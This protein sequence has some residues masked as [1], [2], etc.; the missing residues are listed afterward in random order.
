M[1]FRLFADPAAEGSGAVVVHVPGGISAADAAAA[2]EDVLLR[3]PRAEAV[4]LM[5]DG[6]EA[7]L[8]SRSFLTRTFGMPAGVR[9]T[10]EGDGGS[11]PGEST[12]YLALHYRCA[13]AGC[14]GEGYSAYHDDRF[15]PACPRCGRSMELTG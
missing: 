6:R 12:Q 2:V 3:D 4:A 10:G 14:A 11:L 7:V 8:T 15:R 5:V 1:D 13:E 9:G